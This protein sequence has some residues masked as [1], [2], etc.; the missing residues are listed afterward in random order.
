M[1]SCPLEGN[2]SDFGIF[3]VNQQ[4]IGVDVAFPKALVL[5]MK[6]VVAIL[7]MALTGY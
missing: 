5:P 6:L 1:G 7:D 3:N 4:P 2:D